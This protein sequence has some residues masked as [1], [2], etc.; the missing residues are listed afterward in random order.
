MN[1]ALGADNAAVL[2]RQNQRCADAQFAQQAGRGGMINTP[3]IP[4]TPSNVVPS[5]LELA[6]CCRQ[7]LMALK[8]ML[9]VIQSIHITQISIQTILNKSNANL[10]SEFRDGDQ[11][12]IITAAPQQVIPV[13]SYGGVPTQIASVLINEGFTGWLQGFGIEVYPESA[14]ENIPFQIRVGADPVP[15][16]TSA[17]FMASTLATPLPFKQYVPPGQN[18]SVWAINN[19]T[20]HVTAA[21]ILHGFMRPVN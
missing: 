14:F 4:A 21:A 18:I 9:T 7:Q 11:S 10:T 3:I 20:V 2:R 13:A 5:N 6:E 16:F 17:N 1:G 8:Q 15:K 19:G 12:F